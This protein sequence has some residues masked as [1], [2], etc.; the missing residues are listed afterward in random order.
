MNYQLIISP[1]AEFDV[2]DAFE[3]YEQSNT[4]LGS[5]FVHNF[6]KLK[7]FFFSNKKREK[8]EEKSF[9]STQGAFEV[10]SLLSI[11]RYKSNQLMQL[12]VIIRALIE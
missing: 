8:G 6:V 7:L 12:V 3:W 5:E 11:N 1:E 2:Q 4:G 9:P 10:Q